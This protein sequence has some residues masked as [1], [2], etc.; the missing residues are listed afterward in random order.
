MIARVAAMLL[1]LLSGSVLAQAPAAPRLD[2][3]LAQVRP[4]SRLEVF[5]LGAPDCPYCIEWELKERDDLVAWTTTKGVGYA[6]ILGETLRQP[7]VERHYPP[8]YRW[9]YAQ[10]GPSRGVPRF[11]L[12][13]DGRVLLSTYGTNRYREIFFPALKEAAARRANRL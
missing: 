4:D 5:Y 8:Q 11:L 10:I 2:A 12:A 9:V 3:I 1:L 6:E 13:V 7:I